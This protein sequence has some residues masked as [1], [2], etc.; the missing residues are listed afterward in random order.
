M[1]TTDYLNIEVWVQATEVEIQTSREQLIQSRMA[2]HHC[3]SGQ[4][5]KQVSSFIDRVTHLSLIIWQAAESK[6]KILL[7]QAQKR[8][9]ES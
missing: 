9:K 6:E 3:R 4:L 1:I 7:Y 2:D 5:M 8:D